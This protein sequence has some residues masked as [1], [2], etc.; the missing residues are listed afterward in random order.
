M[1]P[2]GQAY[3]FSCEKQVQIVDPKIASSDNG[4]KQRKGTCP[5]CGKKVSTFIK[6]DVAPSAAQ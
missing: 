6:Q 2:E 1:K 3:C 4:H 5:N